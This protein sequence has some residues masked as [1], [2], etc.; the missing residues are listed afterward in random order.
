MDE[1]KWQKKQRGE[2]E[3]VIL[4]LDELEEGRLLKT[5]EGRAIVRCMKRLAEVLVHGE[6][7]TPMQSRHHV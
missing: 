3:A 1:E 2:L 7:K 6:A 5:E 4:S